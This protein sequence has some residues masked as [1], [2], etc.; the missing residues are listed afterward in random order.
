MLRGSRC[1]SRIGFTLIELLVVIAIIAILIALLLPAVQQAREAARRTQCK[2]NL[3]QIGLALHNYHDTSLVF[4]P[5]RTRNP[6]VADAWYTGNL[7][8][9]ARI[10]AQIEQAP[11]FNQI[12]WGRAGGSTG[13]DGNTGTANTAVR[14]QIIPGY[15]C[16]TDPGR[17][18]VSWKAPDGTMVAGPALTDAYGRLSY[19]GNAGSGTAESATANGIF[20]TNSRNGVR[21]CLDGTSNTLLASE[22]VIG[23]PY[24][25]GSAAEDPSGTPPRCPTTGTPVTGQNDQ[26]GHSWFW[27]YRAGVTMFSTGIGPNWNRNY[28]CGQAS[29]GIHRAA[30]S[31]HTGGVHALLADG[32]V[33]FIS[34]NIDL[35]TWGNLGSRSDGQPLGEF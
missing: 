23:Q 31:L 18:G 24:V 19:V 30:R 34:E 8:W 16:P 3:K 25:A 28:D 20:G 13:T 32:S 27:G 4:P 12:D 1:R 10:L 11:L 33:R 14:A 21:D 9:S 2:N 26:R 29:N 7:V 6:N 17:G 35:T 22:G 5:G 15:L